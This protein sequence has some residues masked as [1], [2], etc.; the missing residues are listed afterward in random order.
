MNPRFWQVVGKSRGSLYYLRGHNWV[1]F[2]IGHSV[3]LPWIQTS[4]SYKPEI[5]FK[6]N[7]EIIW[8]YGFVKKSRRVLALFKS[9]F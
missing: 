1:L 3:L 8:T 9:I 5:V 6:W 4:L 2:S 7:K